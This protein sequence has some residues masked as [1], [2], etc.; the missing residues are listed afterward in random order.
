MRGPDRQNGSLFS[1]V[2]LEERVPARHPLRKIR[3]VVDAAL[4][5]LDADFAALYAVDGRPGIAPERL[6]RAALVQILCSIRS[7]TQLMEQMQYNLL[8]RWFVG[9][10]IDEAVWVPTVFTKNRDRLLNADIA[11]KL[12]TAILAHEKVAPL[13]SDD[14]F[15]VDRMLVEA[16]ASFKSCKP[17][18]AATESPPPA[19][20]PPCDPPPPDTGYGGGTAGTETGDTSEAAGGVSEMGKAG[21]IGRNVERDWRG[22][23]WSNA[24]HAS[25][26][27]PDARLYRKAKGK[28]AQ[29]C[30]MGHALTENRN[31]FVVE[32]TL[33]HADGMA[34][35]HAA[36]D[37][38]N[39]LDPG[40]TRRITLGA[41]KGYDA[42]GFV[43]ELRTMCVTPHIAAKA[44]GSAIDGRTFRHPGYAVSQRKRKRVEEPFGWGK[45]VGPIRTTMLRGLKRVCAQFT[46]TMAAYNLAR[47]PRL[48]AA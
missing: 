14:H 11:R 30:Y 13:L 47:L 26:T 45:T 20:P 31:G 8:F 17:K 19:G 4:I 18:T 3:T 44:K 27:D 1:Y 10:S 40:S 37:M 5:D 22:Q 33:T 25:V 2:N 6:L 35:R 12:M 41:D 9:L 42:A 23:K 48:L 15:S 46:L 32:A 39:A 38:L 28:P 36:I 7:E 16:W 21:G 43:A 34:E 29:L 24:T